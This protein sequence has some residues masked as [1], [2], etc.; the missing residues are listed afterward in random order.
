MAHV[1]DIVPGSRDLSVGQTLLTNVGREGQIEV[2]TTNGPSVDR[3]VL[4]KLVDPFYARIKKPPSARGAV[5]PW[6]PYHLLFLV[7]QNI[8]RLTLQSLA[9]CFQSR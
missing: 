8:T 5:L 2:A 6:T 7:F 3:A 1:S 4:A 9:D